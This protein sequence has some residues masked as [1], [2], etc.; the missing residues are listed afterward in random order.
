MKHTLLQ[1]ALPSLFGF[2]LFYCHYSPRQS[3]VLIPKS[4]NTIDTQDT[5]LLVPYAVSTSYEFATV[6]GV[7]LEI[8]YQEGIK[9]APRVG[10]HIITRGNEEGIGDVDGAIQTLEKALQGSVDVIE[11]T[12]LEDFI[13]YIAT[14]EESITDIHSFGH[15]FDDGMTAKNDVGISM[16]DVVALS[17]SERAS[18]RQK[19]AEGAYWKLYTCHGAADKGYIEGQNIAKTIAET[20]AMTTIASNAWVFIET[21]QDGV[22]MYPASRNRHNQE[23]EMH[24]AN[25]KYVWVPLIDPKYSQHEAAWVTYTVEE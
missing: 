4:I 7:E 2:S 1:T 6:S 12:N 20:L 5:L 25:N 14:S 9:N 23:F 21:T 15:G 17:L 19:L 22:F 13:Q 8:E 16:D 11:V 3:E 18:F 10:K 24:H